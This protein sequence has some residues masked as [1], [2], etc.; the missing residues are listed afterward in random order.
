MCLLF[1]NRLIKY[2][3]VAWNRLVQ[4]L[5]KDIIQ[6]LSCDAFKESYMQSLEDNLGLLSC[7]RRDQDGIWTPFDSMT[8]TVIKNKSINSFL[9]DED[10]REEMVNLYGSVPNVNE[11]GDNEKKFFFENGDS[12]QFGKSPYDTGTK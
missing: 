1:R 10:I 12:S 4:S 8:E 11:M 6:F 7:I 2:I 3:F 5:I 9:C